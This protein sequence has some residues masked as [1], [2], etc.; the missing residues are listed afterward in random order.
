MLA[1]S[2]TMQQKKSS[3]QH[4]GMFNSSS[5]HKGQWT[6]QVWLIPTADERIKGEIS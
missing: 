6:R 2:L 1:T 4:V 3:S 5:P